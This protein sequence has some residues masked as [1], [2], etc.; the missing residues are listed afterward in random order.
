MFN[1]GNSLSANKYIIEDLIY[2]PTGNYNP[3]YIRPYTV[4]VD[5]SKIDTLLQ[6]LED[7]KSAKVNSNILAGLTPDIIQNSVTPVNS[8]INNDWVST[9]KFI[10]LLKVKVLSPNDFETMYYIFGYTNYD[11]ITN[12]GNIDPNLEH[13]INNIIETTIVK[14]NIAG[15]GI[16]EKEMLNKFYNVT[17]NEYGND[18]FTQRPMDIFN[19]ISSY[20]LLNAMNNFNENISIAFNK[21]NYYN[22]LDVRPIVNNLENNIPIEYLSKVI[23]TGLT[24]IPENELFINSYTVEMDSDLAA[25]V[26]EPRFSDNSFIKLLNTIAGN[27]VPTN[28]FTFSTLYSIDST[29]LDRFKLFNITKNYVDPVLTNTPEVGDYWHGQDPVTL[30]AYSIIESSVAM[31][32]KHG[33]SKIYLIA[34]NKNNPLGTPNIFITNFNSFINLDEVSFNTLLEIFKSNYENEIFL[35]E[36]YENRVP[37]HIE[38]FVDILGTSK[39]YIDYAGFGGNWYTIPT[40]ANANFAPVL[41]FDATNVENLAR[42]FELTIDTILSSRKTFNQNNYF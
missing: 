32:L 14:Q 4:N 31:A 2:I 10:F 26:A 6:R 42:N 38:M 37:L 1:Y 8:N 12:S 9:R 17:M 33:F 30:K 7:T 21:G 41:T 24:K 5:G 34:S 20:N 22:Q 25:K 35:N 27:L 18:I 16:Y 11:G 15:Y 39:I 23:N 40:F 29:I 36:S 19:N 3:V 28:K 13:N